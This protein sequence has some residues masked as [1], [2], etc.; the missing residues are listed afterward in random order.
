MC[1]V[2]HSHGHG[3]IK[4]TSKENKSFTLQY[5]DVKVRWNVWPVS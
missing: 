4:K 5:F 3:I 2:D 1:F